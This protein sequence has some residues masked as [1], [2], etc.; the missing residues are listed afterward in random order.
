VA[1]SAVF[2][3]AMYLLTGFSPKALLT[4]LEYHQ[5]KT[6]ANTVSSSPRRLSVF[7]VLY[8]KAVITMPP[9]P[10]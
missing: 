9:L 5:I 1:D 2:L 3:L 6:T 7:Y 4:F 10:S 8:F